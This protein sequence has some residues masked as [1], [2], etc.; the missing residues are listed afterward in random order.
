MHI[1]SGMN[2]TVESFPKDHLAENDEFCVEL[3]F[4][5]P[6]WQSFGYLGYDCM[7]IDGGDQKTIRC[8]QLEH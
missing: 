2:V 6:L 7:H 8:N 5:E 4:Q 1:M 3:S